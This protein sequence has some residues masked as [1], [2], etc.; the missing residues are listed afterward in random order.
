MKLI[1]YNRVSTDEQVKSG[2]SLD[3]QPEVARQWCETNGH[4]LVA[5]IQDPGVSAGKV[6]FMDREGGRQVVG[7]LEQG[8]ADGVVCL[9]FDRMFRIAVDGLVTAEWFLNRGITVTSIREPIDISSQHGWLTFGMMALMSEYER[10]TIAQRAKETTKG[11]REQGRVFGGVP[12]GCVAIKGRL[13]RDP[14]LWLVRE[15]I[16]AL[17]QGEMSAHA[18]AKQMRAD[19]I[20]PPG[21][22]SKGGRKRGGK[23][24][25]HK[26]VLNIIKTQSDLQHI[27]TLPVLHETTFS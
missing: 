16:M 2:V 14:V 18:I 24:W 13:Y 1:A 5:V 11:L 21:G 23:L 7:L 12:F 22:Y 27:E 15:R 4:E 3:L 9:A 8:V 25:H 26:T 17:S 20:A 19:G 10:R 6:A